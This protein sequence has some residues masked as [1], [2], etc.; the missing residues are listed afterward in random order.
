V[1]D[2]P[3]NDSYT[4]HGMLVPT[5]ERKRSE[6]F[7][8]S[9]PNGPILVLAS[10]LLQALREDLTQTEQTFQ[11]TKQMKR[12]LISPVLPYLSPTTINS[13]LSPIMFP[14][15][16]DHYLITLVQYNVLRATL[17]N[18]AILSLMDK[19]PLE[20]RAALSIPPLPVKPP[21]TIPSSLQQTFLQQSTPHNYW[22]RSVPFPAMRDNLIL[23]S[24]QYNEDELCCDLVGGLYE[25]LNDVE[26][27][28]IMVWGEPW[29][30]DSW[31]ASDGFVRKWGFL[32][33]GCGDLIQ[34]TNQWRESRGEERLFVDMP[35]EAI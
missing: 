18:L 20:C 23:N 22:I 17:A 21:T 31:E 34:A 11:A 2:V 5:D 7:S 16:P 12:L 25:G 32:L 30:P 8:G 27:R 15:S 35:D 26:G 4:G 24:G 19:I 1:T 33:Q 28:G 10:P 9:V 3:S 13:R 14:I 29:S 6:H